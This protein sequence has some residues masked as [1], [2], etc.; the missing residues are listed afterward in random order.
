MSRRLSSAKR[1]PFGHL[2]RAGRAL[3]LIFC[4]GPT[5]QAITVH[6]WIDGGGVRHYSDAPPTTGV[7]DREQ[8]VITD[9]PSEGIEAKDDYYSIVNQWQRMREERR[10]S[11]AL[12]LEQARLKVEARAVANTQT[13]E[14]PPAY[15]RGYPIGLY[16][17]PYTR[18]RNLGFPDPHGIDVSNRGRPPGFAAK[19]RNAFVHAT[20]PP[21]HR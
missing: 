15:H 8:I 3:A 17:S 5:A 1:R 6:T 21:W 18:G 12:R 7:A 14:P 11:D 20:P 10:E 16:G 4:C 9:I 13:N 19:R 2:R